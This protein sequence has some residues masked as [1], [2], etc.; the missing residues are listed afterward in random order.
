MNEVLSD[1]CNWV[2]DMRENPE[3][4]GSELANVG[5]KIVPHSSCKCA[6]MHMFSTKA[7]NHIGRERAIGRPRHRRVREVERL[8]W[9]HHGCSRQGAE[10]DRQ[11]SG[12]LK[13]ELKMLFLLLKDVG[14]R[15]LAQF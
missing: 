2:S 13:L 10:G 11:M 7:E 5:G 14:K 4:I 3:I 1:F 15:I 6:I 8:P 12:I 9:K